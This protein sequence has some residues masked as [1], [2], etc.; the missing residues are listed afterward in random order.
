MEPR[1]PV[2]SLDGKVELLNAERA[3]IFVP[4]AEHGSRIRRGEV[5]GSIVNPLSGTVEENFY[6]PCSGLVFTLRAYPVVETGSLIAR[7]LDEEGAQ[8]S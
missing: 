6:A 5:L 3:G 7:I 8:Q 2:V 4:K 1:E